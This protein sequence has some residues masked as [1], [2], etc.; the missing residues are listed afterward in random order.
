MAKLNLSTMNCASESMTQF[1][2][3][4]V[5][6][7]DNKVIDIQR[8]YQVEDIPV[9]DVRITGNYPHLAGLTAAD[10]SDVSLLIGQNCSEA[11]IPYEVRKG[12]QHE[13]YA[14]RTL[15]GWYMSGPVSDGACTSHFIV[16]LCVPSQQ[17]DINALWE[18]DQEASQIDDRTVSLDDKQVLQ[19]W[20]DN[21]QMVDTK[22]EIPIPWKEGKAQLPNNYIMALR[23]LDSLIRRL[24]HDNLYDQYDEQIQKILKEGY[25]EHVPNDELSLND[26]TIWYLPHHHVK[27]KD[28]RIRIVHD[29]AAELNGIS[30]NKACYQGPVMNNLLLGVLLRFR[31][32]P[33]AL[34]GDLEAMFLQL[35]VPPK[36]RNALRFIWKDKQGKIQ[37][38]RM[39]SHLF[40]GVWCPAAAMFVL[41]KTIEL[42][43]D[44]S[45]LDDAM[46]RS[47][48]V[49]DLL[50]SFM[51]KHDLEKALFYTK[52]LLLKGGFN[53]NKLLC[54]ITDTMEKIPDEDKA[55]E[56]KLPTKLAKALG[57]RWNVEQD[58]FYFTVNVDLP[59]VVTKRSMLKCVA[60]VYDPLGMISPVILIGRVLL[61]ET[62]RLKLGWD[63]QVPEDISKKW[64]S[65]IHDLEEI[66]HL[67]IKRCITE[68]ASGTTSY[69]LH[70][71]SDA[72]QTGYGCVSYLRTE[73]Q[74]GFLSVTLVYSK[75]RV[76]PI[77]QITIP[78]LE[79][80]AA[81]LSVK[82]DVTLRRELD[83]CLKESVFWTD[84]RIV[85]SYISDS[86]KRYQMFVANKLSQ[87]RSHSSVD[88]WR[89]IPGKDN[90]GDIASRGAS[91]EKLK[92]SS[93]FRGPTLLLQKTEDWPCGEPKPV[94]NSD[95]EVKKCHGPELATCTSTT[96]AESH[97]YL[98]LLI[99]RKSEFY[100]LKRIVAWLILIKQK[101]LKRIE[102]FE[103]TSS[104]M[105]QAEK[106]L[107]RQE[108]KKLDLK[109]I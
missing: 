35:K 86:S 71:F 17:K 11:L 76:T 103:I 75:A 25:A 80:L 70:H 29:C 36:D 51:S 93:W 3:L 7:Q 108:Q 55:K 45:D 1:F 26:G 102:K 82:V 59:D 50:Q 34:T 67:K 40:G 77:K 15:L 84:S 91:P 41:R 101:L 62:T 21:L 14:V 53:L 37:H 2:H 88:Q 24:E 43:G 106:L 10:P 60:S 19:V 69:Q 81:A 79:L 64:Y 47:F 33:Y 9:P 107:I 95:G 16:N 65:W 6:G 23:R 87:I 85:L 57:V 66:E 52:K 83:L 42:F 54:N 48:Y 31:R 28:G 61:Q 18:I 13:P 89:H 78:R 98:D 74:D 104:V 8:A 5:Q 72:S 73:N 39:T 109:K 97:D 49:D 56:S 46:C 32:Y 12:L 38:F 4:R 94:S 63:Q 100:K 20:E 27:K 105:D 30:L 92:T 58:Q 96:A 90:P 44:N 22:F 99:L 68:F